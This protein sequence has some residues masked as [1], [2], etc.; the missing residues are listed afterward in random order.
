M[1]HDMEAAGNGSLEIKNGYAPKANDTTDIFHDVSPERELP[2][3]EKKLMLESGNESD[4]V[5]K[6][7][8]VG[9]VSYK[10]LKDSKVLNI[11]TSDAEEG[12]KESARRVFSYQEDVKNIASQVLQ[13]GS[14]GD[15]IDKEKK[16]EKNLANARRRIAARLGRKGVAI[17]LVAIALAGG[18]FYILWS[19][20][21]AEDA[22]MKRNIAVNLPPVKEDISKI[23]D[24][25]DAIRIN[26]LTELANVAVLYHIEHGADLPISR[27]Y[28]KLNENNPV[29]EFLR[30]ALRRYNEPEK[31]M[32]DPR[33][34]DFYYAYRS[35]DG[36]SIEFTARLEDPESS[37][38]CKNEDVCIYRKIL[39]EEDID[40][41]S[42]HIENYKP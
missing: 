19:R 35:A 42:D 31:F 3:E 22:A 24:S 25:N 23:A 7:D 28:I 34:P 15:G 1:K 4:D 26:N 41:M 37:S 36:N 29:T 38:Q 18:T 5:I 6:D 12:E 32:N 13:G 14:S 33:H 27:S 2:A 17:V 20:K 40:N 10:M 21:S 16:S 11:K 8:Y 39:I 9:N 30:D